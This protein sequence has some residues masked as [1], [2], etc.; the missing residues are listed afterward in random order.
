[1]PNNEKRI[2]EGVVRS[3][4]VRAISV[5]GKRSVPP[6]HRRLLL[7]IAGLL[8]EE[9]MTM[10]FYNII[11]VKIIP[12]ASCPLICKATGYYYILDI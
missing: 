7:D 12:D 10:L 6:Q 11:P 3:A 2:V 9:N 1:M 4:G 5:S 8:M